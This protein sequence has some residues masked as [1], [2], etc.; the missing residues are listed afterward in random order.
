M[1]SMAAS[2]TSR[3]VV[4][5]HVPF[6]DLCSTLERIQKSKGR[7]EKIRH[8]REF[9]DSWRKFHDALHK[10]QKD[11]TDSFY[12]AMRLILPQLERERMAYGIKETMLAKLYIELLNLPREGKDA[13]KLLN[14]R[15]PTGT[16][17]DAGDFAM[18]AYFVLRP[19]CPKKG[20]L[21]IQQI[22]DLLDSVASNNSAKRK[23]LVKKSLLQLIS[24]SSALEQKW[25]I[26]MIL[27]DLKLGVSQQT[28]FSVFHNDAVELH[29]VTTDLEKVCRQLHDPSVGL[30]D[31]SIT[32]FSA[33]KPM[34]AAIADID[35]IEK[36]MKHQSFYIETKLDGERIQMHKDG[37]VYEYFSRNG[38]NYTEQFGASPDKGSLSPFI[39]NAFKT[40]VQ[41]CILDG[42]M[43]A[44]NPNT[45]TFMQKGIKFDI[46][47]MVED[48]DLQ[49]CYCVFDVL[50]VNNK[51]LAHETLRKRHEIL[52]S[53]L[54]PI[55]GRIEIVQKTQAHSKNE[56]IDALNEA[57]DKR[58]EGVMIK[59]PLS[60]YKPDKRGEG[61][62]KIKPEYVSGLMD[63]L[64]ILIVG[65]YWGKGSRGGMMSHFLCA[66]AEKPPPGEKP[67]VFHTLSRVGSGYTMKELNDLGLKLAKHWKPF[68][69]K[70]P[71][72]SILCGT[73]KP[74]VYIEPCNSVI[75]QVKAAE[76]VPS[77]MYKT[78]YTLRFPRIEKIRDDKE[79]HE[80]MTVD[81][82][83]QLRG[84][85]S[86][87]LASKHF[88][89]GV[90]D[91]PQEKKRKAAPK[92]KKVIGVIEH[93]K[94]P[95]LSNINKV[96]NVFE[97]FEFC[98]MSGTASHPKPD[99]ENKI[100]ELGGYIVQN[101]GSNTYCVIAGSENIRVR[102]IISSNEH[103][104]VKPAWLLECFKTKTCVPWQPCFMIH[105]CPS[106]KQCFAREYDCYGDS[107]FVDTDLNQLK[108]IFSGI[109][110]SNKQTPEEMASVIADLEFR[111]SWDHSPL[112][113][114]RRHTIYLDLYT[115]IN[116]LSTRTEGTRLAIKALELRFHG[117]KVVSCLAEGVSHVIIGE[118]HS[119]VATFKAFRRKL[120]GKFKILK[121]DW[122]T[123]S[124]DK[125]ELQEENQY[126]I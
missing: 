51:K 121:E 35:R 114:F 81:D 17:G 113:L 33:F 55:P 84:K 19:R 43:M 125:H 53:I 22:N 36:D 24:Q 64:D 110:S 105:M 6:A 111:Y 96:S 50:M 116:D 90:D 46:K 80:C 7:E 45:Q 5:S 123:D 60:I 79:W 23:D 98:V 83:Q 112:S 109:K 120:K 30:S 126:L 100:A 94:A 122:V 74:E 8:F 34:L 63:E 32:L 2:Q 103:D 21:T 39:H 82:L 66:V 18:I 12:P 29:N 73:E 92:I 107:Y 25:L 62:L 31:I 69:K 124:I 26:R 68:N 41:I 95:N 28:V 49:T 119:R 71:P 37:A 11:V 48:S 10:N 101:P 38:Y 99:L 52:C 14:Y 58:E 88:F 4:A 1:A 115:V 118:D 56:V 54:T 70:A 65:G 40:D 93:L 97:E 9:L 16:H 87:K 47:R 59:H 67:S 89:V 61:W 44:Y 106:T 57:I 20:S 78:G 27:K 72:S 13:L 86:G 76:I 102:N 15:T 77:D 117:A 108:E 85:A 104:V 91:E 3:T 42:E 75:V